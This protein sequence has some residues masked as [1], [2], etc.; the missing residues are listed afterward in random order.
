MYRKFYIGAGV[1]MIL[2]MSVFV[3][4]M[5]KTHNENKALKAQMAESQKQVNH[6]KEKN[7]VKDEKPVARDGYKMVWHI[8]HWHEV[9]IDNPPQPLDHNELANGVTVSESVGQISQKKQDWVYDKNRKKKDGWR[10]D[11]L[12]DAGDKIIDFNYRPLSEAEQIEYDRLKTNGKLLNDANREA[13]LRIIAISNVQRDGL[14][15]FINS[16]VA[17]TLAGKSDAEIRVK[18]WNYFNIFSDL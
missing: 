1:F 4:I 2:F 17:D 6:I 16:I 3:F 9:P 13:G 5:V 11:L 15:E 14:P 8:D 12:Y 7:A 18:I 10:A